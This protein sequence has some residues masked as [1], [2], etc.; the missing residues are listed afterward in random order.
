[1]RPAN[2][3]SKQNSSIS[4]FDGKIFTMGKKGGTKLIC[5]LAEGGSPIWE[6]DVSSGGGDPNCTPTVDPVAK[7][8]YG[9]S[10]DGKLVCADITGGQEVWSTD[11]QSD[12]GGA[13]MSGW[14]YSESPLVD[15]DRLICTPGSDRVRRWR[16]CF[17]AALA[18]RSWP[19]T[20][21]RGVLQTQS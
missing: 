14:G 1:M 6:L 8:A 20:I 19:S 13:M 9:L 11:F 3:R 7:L 5:V 16:Q 15:G 17:V 10:H 2:T 12:F 18:R 21:G 4:I